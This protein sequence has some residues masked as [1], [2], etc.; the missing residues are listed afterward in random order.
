MPHHAAYPLRQH[1]HLRPLPVAEKLLSR[2]HAG[3]ALHVLQ[4]RFHRPGERIFQYRLL[5]MAA[6]GFTMDV[7]P[8]EHTGKFGFDGWGHKKH[9]RPRP[10]QI[11]P[12]R[13]DD[14]AAS[15]SRPHRQS[16]RQK[17]TRP[18][19]PDRHVLYLH[20]LH[21]HH[22]VQLPAN[23]KRHGI[24]LCLYRRY[25][26]HH[27]CRP[28]IGRNRAGKQLCRIERHAKMALCSRHAFGQAGNLYRPHP[29]HPCL[30]EEIKNA[31]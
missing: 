7:L 15:Q 26:L 18:P 12:A 1:P 31:V 9:T 4:L 11:Q 28:G 2:L 16:N 17:H 20:L 23:G 29:P 5:P 24:H 25:R 21:D 13:N 19:C 6:N 3:P 8:V 27:Q 22:P 30:L 14:T 10:V